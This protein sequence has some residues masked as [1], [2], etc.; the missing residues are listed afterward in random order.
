M[1]SKEQEFDEAEVNSNFKYRIGKPALEQ[2]PETTIMRLT[3]QDPEPWI[4][5]T[6]ALFSPLSRS[7]STASAAVPTSTIELR[8]VALELGRD[9][10][11][12]T[13]Y[14]ER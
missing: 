12:A 3:R 11:R 6:T 5:T 4:A 14:E 10:L 1:L 7:W 13:K 8:I 9:L 2:M